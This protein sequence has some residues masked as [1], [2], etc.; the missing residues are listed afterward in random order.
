MKLLPSSHTLNTPSPILQSE[1]EILDL[2]QSSP[3]LGIMPRPVVR[4]IEN[5][6]MR[7]M[8]IEEKVK[9][10]EDQYSSLVLTQIEKTGTPEQVDIARDSMQLAKERLCKN[11]SIL[12]YVLEK[13]KSYLNN[14]GWV[15]ENPVNGVM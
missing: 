5:E 9:R 15:G 7:V 1:E 10:M 2:L 13:L 8:K 4:D 11:L 3:F 6:E 12:S 14:E